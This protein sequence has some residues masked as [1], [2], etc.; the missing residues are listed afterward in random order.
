MQ[1]L[2]SAYTSQEQHLIKQQIRAY[3][4]KRWRI[5]FIYHALEDVRKHPLSKICRPEGG[6]SFV[7][8]LNIQVPSHSRKT[9]LFHMQKAASDLWAK[10][11][12][13]SS[14]SVAWIWKFNMFLHRKDMQ[15]C[16]AVSNKEIPSSKQKRVMVNRRNPIPCQTTSLLA[17]AYVRAKMKFYQI[18]LLHL[19]TPFFF[20]TLLFLLQ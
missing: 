4:A 8:C 15:K 20:H 3:T 9:S 18:M 11:W 1:N 14:C 7:V 17:T 6:I 19:L 10:E 13:S 16:C 5:K 12:R 2:V